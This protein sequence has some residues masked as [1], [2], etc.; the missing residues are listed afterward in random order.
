MARAAT[1]I[2]LAV[3]ISTCPCIADTPD[4][5]VALISSQ[6]EDLRHPATSSEQL[7]TAQVEEMV[8]R[9][10]D[11][12]GGMASVVADTARL[13]V[14]KP[15]ISIVQ[16]RGSG[17][18]T[19]ARLIRAVAVLVHEVAPDAEILIGEAPG[20]WI[21]PVTADRVGFEMPFF[22]RWLF[23]MREDG[24][25]V[26]GYRDVAREL[27]ELGVDIRCLDMNWGGDG[28]TLFPTGRPGR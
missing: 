4:Y 15:N 14:I 27:V 18:V 8:R 23:D 25:E 24:F 28:H 16:P 17:V 7:S 12:V 21:A 5:A 1:L 2:T 3:C 9:A 10:V 26:G 19:D 22:I 20:G 13:V 6:D 11:L